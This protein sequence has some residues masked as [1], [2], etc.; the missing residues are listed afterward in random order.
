MA[1]PAI[2]LLEDG[3]VFHGESAGAEAL[4][5][6]RL[7][8]S[9]LIAGMP[10]LLTDPAYA[11]TVVCFTYPHVGTAGIVPQDLQSGGI[12][13]R[14][15]IAR[16]TGRFAANRLGVEPMNAWL[17]RNGIPAIEGVDT[18]TIAKKGMLKAVVGTGKFADA[19]LLEAELAK[20]FEKPVTG[21]AAPE[22]W[23]K[24]AVKVLVYDFGAKRGF[25]KKL[26]EKDCAVK[27]VPA[28]HSAR[29]ALAEQPKAIVFSSGSGM[30][31]DRPEAVLAAKE[32]LGKVPLWGIGLGAGII[33]VAAGAK[34]TPGKPHYGI[35]PVGRAG[36]PL[37]EM[38]SQAHEFQMD[39]SSL[40]GAG[41][42]VTYRHLNDNAVEGFACRERGISGH[43]FN[44]EG[45]PG[46]HDSLHLFNEFMQ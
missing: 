42:A 35:Q 30:P 20:P 16:E 31:G 17:A 43:L 10:D 45:E 39:E 8:A 15:V 33:A 23:S 24:G 34:I 6:G 1:S 25:L 21:V 28:A 5:A 40:A 3:S 2:L 44:P 22:E 29:D 26:G 14:A 13:A 36:S 41:L 46:P 4:A 32:L 11:G 12:A 18:R 27:L 9:A 37:G 7:V 19:Q 38:T